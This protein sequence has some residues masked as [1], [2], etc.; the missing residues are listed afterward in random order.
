[1]NQARDIK[2]SLSRQDALERLEKLAGRLGIQPGAIRVRPA[3]G[4][5]AGM[6]IAIDIAGGTL[7]KS[8]DSQSSRDKNFV[9]RG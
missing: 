7:R 4:S 1:M 2:T 9:C 3:A 5:R 8:C 6:S